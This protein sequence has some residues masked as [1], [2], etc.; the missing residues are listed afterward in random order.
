[1]PAVLLDPNHVKS[2][3]ELRVHA[4]GEDVIIKKPFKDRFDGRQYWQLVRKTKD[5]SALRASKHCFSAARS[6]RVGALL[7]LAIQG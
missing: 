3:S 7:A 4:V 5:S 1:M 6:Q 2:C